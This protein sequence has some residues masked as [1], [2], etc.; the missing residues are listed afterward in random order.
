M[1]LRQAPRLRAKL[2][3]VPGCFGPAYARQSLT[4]FLQY[5]PGNQLIPLKAGQLAAAFTPRHLPWN[6]RP[7]R[8][9]PLSWRSPRC[10]LSWHSVETARSWRHVPKL[11]TSIHVLKA[12][13]SRFRS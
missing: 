6:I 3:L 11:L 5:E 9:A 13:I 7:W 8:G 12:N 10:G 1:F 4:I 2:P